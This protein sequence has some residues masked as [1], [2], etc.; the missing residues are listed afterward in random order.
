MSDG[1]WPEWEHVLSAA[2]HLQVV[3]PGTTLVGGTAA[4]RH[5]GTIHSMST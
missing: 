1:T 3:L 2:A 4:R 5:G